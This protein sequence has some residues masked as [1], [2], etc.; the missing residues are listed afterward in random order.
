M[1]HQNKWFRPLLAV[2]GAA[3]GLLL[4]AIALVAGG[5]WYYGRDLP[6]HQQLSTYQP[7]VT[8]RVHAGDGR[9]IADFAREHRL[10][11]PIAAMPKLVIDAFLSAEDKN[12]YSHSG[13]DV[14]GML[15]AAAQNITNVAQDRRL[16]GA[17][18]ITQQ[19]AKNF[20]LSNE[21]TAERKIKEIVLAY[22]IEKAFAKDRILE[23]YL[24]QIYLGGGAYGVAA[25]ALQYF[26]KSLDELTVSEAAF[27][28]ALPKAP[29]NYHPIRFAERARAR[30]DWVIERMAEDGVI[31][32]AAAAAAIALPLNAQVRSDYQLAQAEWFAEE[33]RRQL[34]QRFGEASLYGG[35]LSVHAT[36]DSRLQKIGERALRQ[37]LLDYTKRRGRAQ[38]FGKIAVDG[39]W[40]KQLGNFPRPAGLLADWSVAV[41]LAAKPGEY[42][43]GFA[44][45]S[46]GRLPH[47]ESPKGDAKGPP[48]IGGIERLKAG[49]VVAVVARPNQP[50]VFAFRQPPEVNGGLVAMD[51]HTGR[52]LALVG[53]WAFSQNQ[54]NRATQAARQPGS[55]FKP[56]VY[57]A[58]L[59][60]G[61]T[62]SSLVLDAPFV[63]DQ[64][65]GLGLWKPANYSDDFLGPATVR[66]GLEQSRN[67]M[68]VRLAQAVGMEVVADYA[69]RFGVVDQ[70]EPV[71]AMSLGAGE[72]TLLRLTAAY[73]E[74]VNGGKRI[75]PTLID[76]IQ[77]REG[78]TVYRHDMRPCADCRA[79]AWSGQAPPALPDVRETVIEPTT[80]YQMVA[81]LQGVVERGTGAGVR[82]LNRPLAGK[83]GT[84]NDSADAWFVGFSPD[85]VVG[86]YVGFDSPRS[87]G[88]K[89][90]G[91]SV[92][93]PVFKQFMIEA[94]SNTPA[95][96][97][98]VPPGLTFVRVNP[99]T[100]EPAAADDVSA[101]DEP[102]KPGTEP[103]AEGAFDRTVLGAFGDETTPLSSDDAQAPSGTGG[104]Y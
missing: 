17:S 18:T 40:A 32:A 83:T 51:P 74:F 61:F 10:F 103:G 84:T 8:T 76:R 94:L 64:G 89:E 73:G 104:L 82:E 24:N 55:A 59:D 49:D 63:I 3:F 38:S 20:L 100:G 86:V 45:A 65:A 43:I 80:A 88:E 12:F 91:A 27:I 1:L 87:L 25:A 44:D 13:Y 35:G 57:A 69:K 99:E 53:G 90:T 85:L 101:I 93:V 26:D 7:P 92:A 41:V 23:L 58:A 50:G 28:A 21:V 47:G 33:V 19:I 22:R 54:F 14:F 79:L 97:F 31:D 6:D 67:L 48:S 81:L 75:R 36:M 42:A 70:M 37:G 11:V 78:R 52:V 66:V 77:D 16:V 5:F 72:T 15:R 34:F 95:V 56:F 2:F 60:G 102:F 9:L 4:L 46:R 39:D 30:R 68:T 71:L 96:P 98:R 62:P 29:N